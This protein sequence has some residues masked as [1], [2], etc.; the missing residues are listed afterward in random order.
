MRWFG[1]MC[2]TWLPALTAA[3]PAQI[4]ARPVAEARLQISQR[5]GVSFG[6]RE[7]FVDELGIG[8]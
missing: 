6:V 7:T 4:V 2:L 3:D 5:S 1:A 8:Y